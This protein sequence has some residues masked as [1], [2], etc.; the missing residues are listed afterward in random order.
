[1][2][3]PN[4]QFIIHTFQANSLSIANMLTQLDTCNN[5]QIEELA[6]LNQ[7]LNALPACVIL[8]QVDKA[9]NVS[10][11]W[12][13][14]KSEEVM[15]YNLKQIP[16][17]QIGSSNQKIIHPHDLPVI[18]KNLR[19]LI[20]YP[21]KT[22]AVFL[23]IMDPQYKTR[24]LYLQACHYKRLK[25]STQIL[26]LATNI[27]KGLVVNQRNLDIYL[28]EIL[29]SRHEMQLCQLTKT[30]LKISRMLGLGLTTK[31]VA[32]KLNRSY[33][34]VNNHKRHVFEKMKFHKLTELVHFTEE[35]GLL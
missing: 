19:R 13:N 6:F 35:C 17:I 8:L 27:N 18:Q 33:H 15:G 29:M 2:V 34:T 24:W 25:Q 3:I 9:L 7:I 23:R 5:K 26:C 12:I 14:S 28:K 20:K 30:E 11:L 21:S 10:P 4:S 1:M 16:Q 31:E 22:G 32:K